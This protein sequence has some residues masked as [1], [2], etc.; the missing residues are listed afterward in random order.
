MMRTIIGRH[1]PL[2]LSVLVLAVTTAI[3][4]VSIIQHNQ[5]HF[6]YALDDVYI[7]LAMARNLSQHG[8]W[9]ISPSHFTSSASSLLWI[10]ILS[11]INLILGSHELTPLILDILLATALLAMIHCTLMRHNVGQ[12]YSFCILMAVT[13]ITPL[14]AMIFGGMEHIL[15]TLLYIMFFYRATNLLQQPVEGRAVYDLR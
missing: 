7:H 14:P 12:T 9:G 4:I 15:Q 6:G 3:L 2:V 13:F 1:W 5:G 11:A 10:L 8:V